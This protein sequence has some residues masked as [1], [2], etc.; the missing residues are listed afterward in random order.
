MI[1]F[2]PIH[3]EEICSNFLAEKYNY[4]LFVQL[5]YPLGPFLQCLKFCWVDLLNMAS[6]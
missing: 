4:G 1:V 5:I 3:F 2:Q 6:V